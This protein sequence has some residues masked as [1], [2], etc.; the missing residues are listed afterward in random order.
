[1]ELIYITCRDMAEAKKI[2]K[3]LLDEKLIACSN[4][5][6]I[7]S[8]FHWKGKLV[9]EKEVVL[10]CKSSRT[11]FQSLIK[12]VE[13][14]HS[15]DVPCIERISTEGSEKFEAWAKKEVQ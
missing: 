15:Y 10:L 6:P 1:M 13:E 14:M 12:V 3:K 2:S 8:M 4:M 9:D 5:F 11:E 7:S